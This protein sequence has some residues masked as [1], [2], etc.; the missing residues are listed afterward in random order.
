MSCTSAP[1]TDTQRLTA[2]ARERAKRQYRFVGPR[3]TIGLQHPLANYEI[4]FARTP[5]PLVRERVTRLFAGAR[6]SIAAGF[7]GDTRGF[8]YVFH[9]LGDADNIVKI[10]CTERKPHKRVA[11]WNRELAQSTDSTLQNVVLLFAYPTFANTFAEEIIFETLRCERI[12]N[13]LNPITGAELKEFFTI[14]NFLA[15]K[16]FLR[17]TIAYID[18]FVISALRQQREP[19]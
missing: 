6:Q 11:E 13:R 19:E 12:G 4:A 16:V 10:G 8:I 18:N 5:N 14:N 2:I 3:T 15:L 1:V 17:Q 7:Y 9:D